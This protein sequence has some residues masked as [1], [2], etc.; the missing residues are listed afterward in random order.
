MF[1]QLK[2]HCYNIYVNLEG[3]R[4]RPERERSKHNSNREEQNG[5]H[6]THDKM[7]SRTGR[8]E[9]NRSVGTRIPGRR[10]PETCTAVRRARTRTSTMRHS[11]NRRDRLEEAH[12]LPVGLPR[13]APGHPVVLAGR[14]P[15]RQ[16]AEA[17]TPPVRHRHVIDPT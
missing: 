12:G 5:V 4:T 6:P 16:R 14:R 7:A 8:T 17:Q 2:I 9:A 11:G 3:D 15:L 1:E 10:R 13:P